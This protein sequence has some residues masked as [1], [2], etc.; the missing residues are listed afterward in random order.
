MVEELLKGH[1][2]SQETLRAL[3]VKEFVD[4]FFDGSPEA[5]IAFLKKSPAGADLRE[6]EAAYLEWSDMKAGDAVLFLTD[7]ILEAQNSAEEEF[8]NERLLEV[9]ANLRGESADRILARLFEA[10]DGFVA[11]AQQ[12]PSLCRVLSGGSL[13]GRIGERYGML[14]DG[15]LLSSTGTSIRTSCHRPSAA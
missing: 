8:G 7:G 2:L 15:T 1:P 4:R 9:C 13:R 14:L 10:V 12:H 3:A 11:G 5:L 6:P